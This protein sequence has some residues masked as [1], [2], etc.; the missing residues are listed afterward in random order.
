MNPVRVLWEVL[1]IGNLIAA[2]ETT[3]ED[4]GAGYARATTTYAWWYRPMVAL[5]FWLCGAPNDT[6]DRQ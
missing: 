2:P 5:A 3:I 4:T 1:Q 6:K